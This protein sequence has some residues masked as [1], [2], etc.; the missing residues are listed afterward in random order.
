MTMI[1]RV[2]VPNF[3]FYPKLMKNVTTGEW[4]G[5]YIDFL[6]ELKKKANFSYSF[7]INELNS[8]DDTGD[9]EKSSFM[10]IAPTGPKRVP[11]QCLPAFLANR[12]VE[13]G[14]VIGALGQSVIQLYIYNKIIQ[15]FTKPFKISY[16]NPHC[17]NELSLKRPFANC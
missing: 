1:L 3:N 13:C 9:K 5:V 4:S 11:M 16:C 14:A 8:F 12:C 15:V 10:F 7:V 6:E 17:T 2:G